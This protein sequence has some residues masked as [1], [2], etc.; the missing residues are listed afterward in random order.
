ML[1]PSLALAAPWTTHTHTPSIQA[2]L[3]RA[4]LQRI[5]LELC[6]FSYGLGELLLREKEPSPSGR[7]EQGEAGIYSKLSNWP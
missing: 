1:F 2:V 6:A 7:Q 4:D 3:S 5:S